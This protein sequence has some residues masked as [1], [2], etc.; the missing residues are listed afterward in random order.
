[1]VLTRG[2]EPGESEF[3]HGKGMSPPEVRG[4]IP[5]NVDQLLAER[6]TDPANPDAS[7]QGTRSASPTVS[8]LDSLGR[9]VPGDLRPEATPRVRESGL[10]GGTRINPAVVNADHYADGL[11]DGSGDA[12]RAS[13]PANPQPHD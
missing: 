10:S 11:Q 12:W 13:L 1:M 9:Y 3:S 6:Q 2:L 7:W 4:Y 8:H 5:T